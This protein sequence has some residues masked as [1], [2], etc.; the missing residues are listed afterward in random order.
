MGRYLSDYELSKLKTYLTIYLTLPFCEDVPGEVFEQMYAA[1]RGG[2]WQGKRANRPEPDV[3]VDG[4]RY[5]IKTEK[6]QDQSVSARDIIG[7]RL[8]IITA[9]PDPSDLLP[10]DQDMNDLS[11]DELGRLVLCH[12]N[13]RII[14]AY[15][16]DVIGILFRLKNN[17]EF[18]YFEEPAQP[19]DV[20]A[21]SWK[22][23]K[24]AR[25]NN[26]NI[27]GYDHQGLQKFRW[28]SRG[29]QLYVVHEI[30]QD[31]EIFSIKVQKINVEELQRILGDKIQTNDLSSP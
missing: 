27:A 18:V 17:R 16:W 20:K 19:Y 4:R 1:A 30:P 11:D 14:Q 28:T 6:I 10:P 23:T 9:R 31:A 15:Q 25:G 24:R 5:S 13:E 22:S 29:K 12:Y 26:R 2:Q 21:Y 8:D 7:K 3:I